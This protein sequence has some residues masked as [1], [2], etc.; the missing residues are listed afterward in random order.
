MGTQNCEMHTHVCWLGAS[1]TDLTLVLFSP[2]PPFL[3]ENSLLQFG[4]L[5]NNG[6][7]VQVDAGN[8]GVANDLI[9]LTQISDCL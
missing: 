4:P 7:F 6:T 3:K 1:K 5:A 9:A 8:R 2:Q